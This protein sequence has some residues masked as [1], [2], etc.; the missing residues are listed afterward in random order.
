MTGIKTQEADNTKLPSILPPTFNKNVHL[1]T[2]FLCSYRF[3]FHIIS[4]LFSLQ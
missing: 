1:G 2:I 4:C 3:I